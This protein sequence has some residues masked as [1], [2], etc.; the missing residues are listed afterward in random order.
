MDTGGLDLHAHRILSGPKAKALCRLV[1]PVIAGNY[2]VDLVANR[3][4]VSYAA[5]MTSCLKNE[6]SLIYLTTPGPVKSVHPRGWNRLV[7][8][9]MML[10]LNLQSIPSVTW[11]FRTEPVVDDEQTT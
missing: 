9:S 2:S 4:L 6:E 8:L 3:F 7:D 1:S 11:E 5:T 10:G